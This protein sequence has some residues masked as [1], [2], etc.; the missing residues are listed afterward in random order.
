[1][2]WALVLVAA[3]G[4]RPAAAVSLVV[5]A[6]GA[7]PFTAVS[8]LADLELVKDR[9][10]LTACF[11][12]TRSAPLEISGEG[13]GEDLT[14][15]I[16]RANQLCLGLDQALNDHWRVSA[17]ASLAPKVSSQIQVLDRPTL[18]FRSENA[19]AGASVSVAYDTASLDDVQ[20]GVDLGLSANGYSLSHSWITA[21]RTR[22]FPSMLGSLRPG[23][24]VVVA[25]GDTQLQLRGSYTFYSADP[26]QVGAVSA[27]E[28]LVVDAVVQRYVDVSK[29]YGLNAEY[30]SFLQQTANRLMAA[31]ALSGLSSAPIW[32]ELRPSVQH[33]FTRWLRGQVGYTYNQYVPGAGRAHVASTK[34]TVTFSK[35]FQSWVAASAQLDVPGTVPAKVYGILTLGVEVSF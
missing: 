32:F 17:M 16:P 3:L 26:L 31:D 18:V 9:T 28:L 12:S 30:G 15:N 34:W 21:W 7:K 4:A 5:E 25:L 22:R 19:S 33:R 14:V 27:G 20:W 24:G 13:T 11:G 29:Y 1:M 35:H 10:F 23:L 2:R 8:L 6:T